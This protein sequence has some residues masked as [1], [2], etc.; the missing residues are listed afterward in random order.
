MISDASKLDF[1]G[2][3]KMGAQDLVSAINAGIT[4]SE[5]LLKL[6]TPLGEDVLLPQRVA[7]TS[8]IGRN[9]EFTVDAVS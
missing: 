6:D 1:P 3:R 7:G 5:R 2:T 9:F 4:Q 8:R